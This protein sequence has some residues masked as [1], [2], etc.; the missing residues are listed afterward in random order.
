MKILAEAEGEDQKYSKQTQRFKSNG[1]KSD[2][3]HETGEQ[4]RQKSP[5]KEFDGKKPNENLKNQAKN[6]RYWLRKPKPEEFEKPEGRGE[7]ERTN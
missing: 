7:E 1:S 2:R 5:K 3:R 4:A 6:S